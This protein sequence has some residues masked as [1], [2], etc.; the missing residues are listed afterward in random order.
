MPEILR[1]PLNVSA[2]QD[3]PVAVHWK[4]HWPPEDHHEILEGSLMD[5]DA[6]GLNKALGVMI[7]FGANVRGL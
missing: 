4:T 3:V 6:K 2:L 5:K 1:Q 7:T